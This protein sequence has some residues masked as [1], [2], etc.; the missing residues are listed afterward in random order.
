M[1][2]TPV[3]APLTVPIVVATAKATLK[4]TL[5]AAG[6]GKWSLANC[7]KTAVRYGVCHFTMNFTSRSSGKKFKCSGSILVRNIGDGPERSYGVVTCNGK[8][9]N[10]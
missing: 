2:V 4:Q 7:H 1:A 5:A 10:V 8:K 9:V 6:T 3:P